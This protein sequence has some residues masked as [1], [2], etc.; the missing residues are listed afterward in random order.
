MKSEAIPEPN[1]IVGALGPLPEAKRDEWRASYAA[2]FEQAMLDA[3]GDE[4]AARQ[5]AHRDANRM[6]RVPKPTSLKAAR[7][8]EDWQLISRKDSGGTFSIVT[9]DGARFSFAV[10]AAPAEKA[11]DE[12]KDKK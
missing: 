10:P 5:A 7:A 11:K 6:F 4:S 3:G 1:E 12:G 9:I 2:A 8:L